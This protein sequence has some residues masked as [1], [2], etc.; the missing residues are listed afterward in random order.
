MSESYYTP[1]IEGGVVITSKIAT[2]S[3][4]TEW[5]LNDRFSKYLPEIKALGKEK[6]VECWR[7]IRM[8]GMVCSPRCAQNLWI[9]V[10]ESYTKATGTN[11]TFT[12]HIHWS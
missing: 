5:L 8:E 10:Q 9:S 12:D 6:C 3:G 4:D 7:D 2:M 1:T 11:F